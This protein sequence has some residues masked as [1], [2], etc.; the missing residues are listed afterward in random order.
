MSLIGSFDCRGPLP[1]VFPRS[2]VMN[3]SLGHAR[4]DIDAFSKKHRKAAEMAPS[5]GARVQ[6]AR[7]RFVLCRWCLSL[8]ELFKDAILTFPPSG[9][10]L[11]GT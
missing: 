9:Y 5:S 6:H 2:D 1:P 8:A 3:P 11:T 10:T 7:L 4:V